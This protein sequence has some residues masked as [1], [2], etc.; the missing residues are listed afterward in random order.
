MAQ[1][2]GRTDRASDVHVQKDEG[3]WSAFISH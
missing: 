1:E 3:A 2:M